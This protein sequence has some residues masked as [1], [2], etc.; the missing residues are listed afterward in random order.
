ML[1]FLLYSVNVV[2]EKSTG[3]VFKGKVFMALVQNRQRSIIKNRP[4]GHEPKGCEGPQHCTC[5][6]ANSCRF[7]GGTRETCTPSK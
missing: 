6:I 4:F 2:G 5:K 7:K 3:F 1:Q